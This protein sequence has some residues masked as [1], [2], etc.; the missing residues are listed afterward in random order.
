MK[1]KTKLIATLMAMCLVIT[2]GVFG[3]LAVKTLNMSVG[4]NITFTADGIAFEVS[5][6]EFKTESGVE[7][8]GITSQTGKLQGFAMNTNTKLADVQDK[9][10][11]WAGLDLVATESLGDPVLHFSI[12]NLMEDEILSFNPT[13]TLGT[14]INDN[15]EIIIE[16]AVANIQATQ[17][18][19][20]TITFHVKDISINAGLTG[21]NYSGFAINILLSTALVVE[22]SE[23]SDMT[24]AETSTGSNE[25]VVS[26]CSDVSG[27][28]V[29]PSYVKQGGVN[30]PVTK[31]A[32]NAFANNTNITS[33]TI[34]NTVTTIG[35]DAFKECLCVGG[36]LIIP[37]SVKT[38]GDSAFEWCGITSLIIGNGVEEIDS[39]AFSSCM[40]LTGELVI[41]DSVKTI[42]SSA[43]EFCSGLTSLKLG[44]S[45]TTIGFGAFYSCS[46][47]TGE[48][49]IPDSVKTVGS[50]AFY[51]CS[52]LTNVVIGN[53]V[54][55]IESYAFYKCSGLTSVVIGDSVETLGDSAFSVC[56][57][58]TSI[59][60][61]DS[62]L[63]IG[64]AAFS[65]CPV[66]AN[67]VFGNSLT[68]IG[69]NAFCGTAISG[70]L[71]LPDSVKILDD[72][73]FR[74]CS[75]LTSLVLGSKLQSIGW[76]VFWDCGNFTQITIKAVNPP[77]FDESFNNTSNCT[78][79][80]PNSTYLTAS[81]WSAYASQMVIA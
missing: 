1:N 12:K 25:Y 78:F 61:P 8:T 79:Y 44:N 19:N 45:V 48:L 80:V 75:N 26:N 22:P 55:T 18:Q 77:S 42:N 38:I 20:F 58:L 73:A 10:N 62:V 17:S 54:T 63:T 68:T 23:V 15:M 47:L 69:S 51:S 2:L 3:I 66:L 32:D 56:S 7:Y 72:C 6:G 40:S 5:A 49:V 28:V 36:E 64:A 65:S 50:N 76:K 59:I 34:P 57:K 11:S 21:E 81:G 13:I 46:G 35:N 67:V 16:P 60:I 52:S 30:Y 27:D 41:P 70:E 37:N 53:G 29:I 9:I 31:I 71:I 39:Q 43:F 33:I 14:N 4:G 74:E 24:F